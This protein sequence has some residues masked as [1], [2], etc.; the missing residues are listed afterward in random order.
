MS[1]KLINI[2]QLNEAIVNS[3]DEY[4]REVIDGVKRVTK[5]AMNQLVKD[6]KAT[7]PVGKRAKHYK[8]NITS[9]TLSESDYGLSKLWYVRGSD[10]R[11]THLLNN[12]HALRDGGRYPGT[13]FL[14]KAVDKVVPDYMKEIE[15][16]LK[17][18]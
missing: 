10:Y 12:G 3:L 17:N 4:N 16:V 13:N 6:S 8:D 18:G 14:G 5:K 2:D 15:E 9:K 1:D 7:A 11:L